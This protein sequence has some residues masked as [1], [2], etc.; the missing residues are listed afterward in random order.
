MLLALTSV[1]MTLES[2]YPT[3]KAHRVRHVMMMSTC[4]VEAPEATTCHLDLDF[5]GC[6]VAPPGDAMWH[7]PEG[8]MCY[9]VTWR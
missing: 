2:V 3:W 7:H 8:A 4:H 9:K 1:L 6:H 5:L